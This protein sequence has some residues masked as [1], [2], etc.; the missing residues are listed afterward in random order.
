MRLTRKKPLP[1]PTKFQLVCRR[2][3]LAVAKRRA[4]LEL[5]GLEPSRSKGG[6]SQGGAWPKRAVSL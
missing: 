3:W 1:T 2:P 6:A 4:S 5:S